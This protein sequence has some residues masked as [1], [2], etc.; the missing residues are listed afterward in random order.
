MEGLA[1]FR[2]QLN[3]LDKQLVELLGERIAICRDVA[4]FKRERG[5]AMMQSARVDE[6]K[7]R[8]AALAA[9]NDVDPDFARRLYSLIIDET[10]RVESEIIDAANS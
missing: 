10:C 9:Q 8:C 7:E 1:E 4:R 3:A 2:A 5:I 6:V